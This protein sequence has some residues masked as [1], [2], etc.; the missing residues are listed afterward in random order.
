MTGRRWLRA[1]QRRPGEPA[2]S[3]CPGVACCAKPQE[4]SLGP[5]RTAAATGFR[6]FHGTITPGGRHP[7]LDGPAAAI[8]P[9]SPSTTPRCRTARAALLEGD[10]AWHLSDPYAIAPLARRPPPR[11]TASLP[12]AWPGAVR[13]DERSAPEPSE[14]D[15]I[16]RTR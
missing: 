4:V 1:G 6:V 8:L 10:T 15:Q 7:V 14:A 16:R 2:A 3:C 12:H 9:T 5:R 13:T 11:A